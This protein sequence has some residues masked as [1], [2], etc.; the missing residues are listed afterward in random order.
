MKTTKI[1]DIQKIIEIAL[2]ECSPKEFKTF[3]AWFQD[4]DGFHPTAETLAK[5]NGSCRQ[6][7]SKNL[8]SLVK[9]ELLAPGKKEKVADGKFKNTYSLGPI[10]KLEGSI[11]TKKEK[12]TSVVYLLPRVTT[13]A[14][15]KLQE[16]GQALI[17]FAEKRKL[18]QNKFNSRDIEKLKSKLAEIKSLYEAHNYKHFD[19]KINDLFDI[20]WINF[21]WMKGRTECENYHLLPKLEDI[22]LPTLPEIKKAKAQ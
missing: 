16:R 5:R 15:V 12:D 14:Y 20:A 9:K 4:K 3:M 13:E 1:T 8:K 11:K 6:T 7:E 17:D 2:L 10:F 19:F 18:K 22:V 21:S